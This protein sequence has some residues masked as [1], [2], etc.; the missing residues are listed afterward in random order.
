[1]GLPSAG[2]FPVLPNVAVL[3]SWWLP[4]AAEGGFVH[5][6]VV[7]LLS[8]LQLPLHTV[9]DILRFSGYVRV[10]SRGSSLPVALIHRLPSQK[11]P[12]CLI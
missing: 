6:D 9:W 7:P 10:Q 2:K 5:H 4:G 11:L 3:R 12:H 8:R 1:M